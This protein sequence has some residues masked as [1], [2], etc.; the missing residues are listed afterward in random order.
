MAQM[1]ALFESAHK[2]TI[3][4]LSTGAIYR[5]MESGALDSIKTGC[6][7]GVL[8]TEAQRGNLKNNS[9]QK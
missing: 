3:H 2:T 1:Q 5:R 4:M 6:C 7:Q 9:G 8:V